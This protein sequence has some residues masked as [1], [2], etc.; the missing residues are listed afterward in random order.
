MNTLASQLDR[1][2][3]ELD[4]ETARVLERLVRVAISLVENASALKQRRPRRRA[5]SRKLPAESR[6]QEETRITLPETDF[7]SFCRILD[8][9]PRDL[10]RLRQLLKRPSRLADA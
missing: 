8:A 7:E 3:S 1:K 4:P 10:P 5:V 2:L 6:R 9:A